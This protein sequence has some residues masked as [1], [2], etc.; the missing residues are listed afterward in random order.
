MSSD[1][2]R[3]EIVRLAKARRRARFVK[4][5]GVAA[6]WGLVA[7]VPV[8]FL[9]SSASTLWVAGAVLA[10][11]LLGALMAAALVP[12]DPI[13][14]AKRYD[15]VA[16]T[17]DLLSSSLGLANRPLDGGVGSEARFV[18]AVH[19]D[20]RR[21]T[22][23]VGAERLYPLQAPREARLLPLPAAAITVA[24]LWPVLM[25]SRPPQP[26]LAEREALERGAQTLLDVLQRHRAD[27]LG[28]MD[29]E[30]QKRIQDLI[31]RLKREDMGKRDSLAEIAKLASQLDQERKDLEQKKLQV[32]KNATKLTSGED[33]KDAR[34]DMDAGRYREA[35][36]K[37]KKKV[38]ELEK[39]LEE[40]KK[41]MDKLAIEKLQQRL[42][43]LKELLAEL[44]QLDALGRDLGFLVEVLEALDRI[45]GEL[46]EL[47]PFEGDEFDEVKLGRLRP[48]GDPGDPQE[49]AELF[50]F[51]SNEAGKGHAKK[52]LGDARRALTQRQEHEAKMKEGKGKSAFGQVKTANDKSQSK[53]AYKDTWLAARQAAEDA[54]YRQN[55]PAGYRTY[56]RRYFE[57]MQPDDGA[58]PRPAAAT[59][60]T[61]GEGK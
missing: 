56:I 29:L 15:D 60:P 3:S 43:N 52:A 8:A 16:G 45:E 26:T 20:A 57:T 28:D 42:A 49:G 47:R 58:E 33:A 48:P 21:A 37:L 46:G 59:E 53:L 5:L 31:D 51:P 14:V 30:R 36:N 18:Q 38:K 10:A 32:E 4:V 11:A 7:V 23:L 9:A 1:P 44:E 34:S 27:A 17:K 41:K 55:I 25:A 6:F 12:V 40:A 2:V 35:A 50:A 22:G 19:E 13:A 61:G 39:L 24:L 54:V